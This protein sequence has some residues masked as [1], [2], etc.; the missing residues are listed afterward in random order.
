MYLYGVFVQHLTLANYDSKT[1]KCMVYQI[2]SYCS[3][4]ELL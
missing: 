4:Y 1:A 2:S 3:R